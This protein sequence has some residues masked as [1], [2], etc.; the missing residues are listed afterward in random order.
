MQSEK[1]R[2]REKRE[3]KI[4]KERVAAAT[5]VSARDPERAS[6]MYP[7]L[8]NGILNEELKEAMLRQSRIAIKP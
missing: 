1:G 7:A 4:K 5:T 6:Q 2:E 8:G 3:I